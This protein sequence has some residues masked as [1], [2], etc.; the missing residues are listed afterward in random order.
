MF[1]ENVV[2]MTTVENGV[3]YSVTKELH[4]GVWHYHRTPIGIEEKKEETN[5]KK[6]K[7][8]EG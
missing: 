7:K 3:I 8:A 6:T 4:S 1:K 5:K 2:I